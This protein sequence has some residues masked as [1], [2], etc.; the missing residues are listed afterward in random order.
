ML[1]SIYAEL[2]RPELAEAEY[3]RAL[4]LDPECDEALLG[5]GHLRMEL[6]QMDRAEELFL[7]AL[8]FKPDNLAARIHIS[9][10][11]KA[12]EGRREFCGLARGRKKIRAIFP[13]TD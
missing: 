11:K 6:G 4:S 13:R 3:N 1:G 5:L 2:A 7:R 10:V 8:E 9:Q 12:R